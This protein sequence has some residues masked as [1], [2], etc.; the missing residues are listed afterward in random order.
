MDEEQQAFVMK[1]KQKYT[2]LVSILTLLMVYLHLYASTILD[3]S[4]SSTTC[5]PIKWVYYSKV[6]R[7]KPDGCCIF[8]LFIDCDY[9]LKSEYDQELRDFKMGVTRLIQLTRLAISIFLLPFYQ[10]SR[11]AKVAT[12][13]N[14][15]FLPT[16]AQAFSN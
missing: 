2:H 1:F 9:R 16:V 3:T 12:A 8:S 4:P 15:F 5:L 13:S 10:A 11:R 7:F 6:H 14:S